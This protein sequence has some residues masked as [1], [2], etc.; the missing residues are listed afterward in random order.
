MS[1]ILI[2]TGG[3]KGIGKGIIEAYLTAGYQIFSIARST[4][5][6][7]KNIDNFFILLLF[8]VLYYQ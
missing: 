4:N 6:D 2:I 5:N 7:I 1:K 8:R 3:S